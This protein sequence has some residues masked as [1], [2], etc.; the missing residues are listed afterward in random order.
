MNLSNFKIYFLL[1]LGLISYLTVA[2]NHQ[3]YLI[4]EKEGK[5][6]EPQSKIIN[7]NG[8]LSLTFS[9]STLN[10]F[11]QAQTV[12]KYGK[13]FPTATSGYLSRVYEVIMPENNLLPALSALP[14][15]ELTELVGEAI[16]MEYPDDYYSF[17]NS[18]HHLDLIK[19]PQAWDITKGDPNIGVGIVD[20][21]FN[22]DHEEL[23]NKIISHV[24]GDSSSNH[25]G[26]RVAGT[27]SCRNQ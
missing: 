9:D 22:L 25:H 7:P 24:E 23:V 1:L 6:L 18:H 20:T 8:T 19:A 5:S 26:T 21:N 16:P 10:S 27:F 15:I 12:Y 13:A 11:F 4:L 17:N 14:N 3:S 2:Q